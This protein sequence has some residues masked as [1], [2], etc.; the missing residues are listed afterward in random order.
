[1]RDR[2][3]AKPESRLASVMFECELR[4][5]LAKFLVKTSIRSYWLNKG[6]TMERYSVAAWRC[7]WRNRLTW[8]IQGAAEH[9]SMS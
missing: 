2:K 6:V 1:M 3:T 8:N 9:G 7:L 4:V 5:M